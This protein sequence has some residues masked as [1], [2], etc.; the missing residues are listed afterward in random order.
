LFIIQDIFINFSEQN[1]QR[2]ENLNEP[3]SGYERV[4]LSTIEI[5]LVIN[6]EIQLSTRFPQGRGF[7]VWD[8]PEAKPKKGKILNGIAD[9]LIP[10]GQSINLHSK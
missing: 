8:F 1:G 10:D 3:V 5:W 7:V 6:A 4:T 9:Y 2:R